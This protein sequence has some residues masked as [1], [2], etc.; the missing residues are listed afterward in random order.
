MKQFL[1]IMILVFLVSGCTSAPVTDDK[2]IVDEPEA[3]EPRLYT[4][5]EA[6]EQIVSGF[7]K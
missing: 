3:G 7:L 2:P 1:T 6:E 5:K 4:E